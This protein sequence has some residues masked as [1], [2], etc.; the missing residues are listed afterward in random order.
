MAAGLGDVCTSVVRWC[1]A[2]LFAGPAAGAGARPGPKLRPVRAPHRTAF[3]P[4]A[5]LSSPQFLSGP[6]RTS[7]ASGSDFFEGSEPW[8]RAH[9]SKAALLSSWRPI[10]KRKPSG[11]PDLGSAEGEADSRV[12]CVP[13][14]SCSES[15]SGSSW[16]PVKP[17][18]QGPRAPGPQMP[19][20]SPSAAT[21]FAR[22]DT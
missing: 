18:P 14:R 5:P 7:P 22:D 16:L 3:F 9:S 1:S 10:S 13:S 21:A 2:V 20:A 6:L 17:G 15:R 12:S 4:A 19:Q 8:S 11:R